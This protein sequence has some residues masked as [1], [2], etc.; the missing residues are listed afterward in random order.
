MSTTT[1]HRNMD[2]HF[3]LIALRVNGSRPVGAPEERGY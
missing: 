1:A 2:H 3:A